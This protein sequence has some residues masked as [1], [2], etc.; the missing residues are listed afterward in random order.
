MPRVLAIGDIH[1]CNVA[2]AALL[3]G[4]TPTADDIVVMLGDAIDRGPDSRGVLDRLLELQD[5]CRLVCI[6]GNHEQMLLEALAGDIAIHEWLIHGGAETLDSYG[7]G[8]GINAVEPR[9]IDFMR[10]FGDVYE[11]DSH[12]FAHGNYVATRPFDAQPWSDLRWQS[13]AWHTPAPHISGKTAVLGHTSQKQGLVVNLGHLLCIDTYCCGGY[14][15][16]AFDSTTGRLWQANEAG[17]FRS[18]ELP[19]IQSTLAAQK[20]PSLEGRG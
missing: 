13:L 12:F 17:K 1:G 8:A 9:H 7:R 15:L 2:L 20:S 4:L 16:T 6:M 10:S 14:W 5:H 11:T 18:I 19:P 3:D